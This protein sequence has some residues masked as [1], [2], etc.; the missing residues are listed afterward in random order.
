MPNLLCAPL[1]H[2]KQLECIAGLLWR[3][4]AEEVGIVDEYALRAVLE[5]IE[6]K[7][8][9]NPQLV[10]HGEEVRHQAQLGEPRQ[11]RLPR[12][13]ERFAFRASF[14][15]KGEISGPPPSCA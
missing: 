10:G 5:F 11:R 13:L 14:R 12:K 7:W 2:P 6:G 8:P 3:F 9:T 1:F 4:Q 15:D